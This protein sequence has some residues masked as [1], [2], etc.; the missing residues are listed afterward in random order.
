MVTLL[1]ALIN[2]PRL[3]EKYKSLTNKFVD[4]GI[5]TKE[6]TMPLLSAIESKLESSEWDE[7]KKWFEEQTTQETSSPTT[8]STTGKATTT[9]RSSTTSTLSTSIRIIAICLT[10]KTLVM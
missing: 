6:D 8:S 1:S 2:S 3:H 4:D 5:L 7:T 9:T 10:I